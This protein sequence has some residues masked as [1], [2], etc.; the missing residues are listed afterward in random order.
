MK[1]TIK[2]ST[3][4]ET[5]IIITRQPA[6]TGVPIPA[7]KTASGK[8]MKMRYAR[9]NFLNIVVFLSVIWF[10]QHIISKLLKSGNSSLSPHAS[11]FSLFA[12]FYRS[13]SMRTIFIWLFSM[14]P[15]SRSL[16]IDDFLILM[17]CCFPSST[18]ILPSPPHL[19]HSTFFLTYPDFSPA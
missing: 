3:T 1:M 18:A 4:D 7:Y 15:V 11:L 8:P 16:L 13:S 19:S 6:N 5:A 10:T 9:K 12:S 17:I 14:M 2:P